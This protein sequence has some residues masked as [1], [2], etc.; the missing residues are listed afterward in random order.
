MVV[1]EAKEISRARV[2]R[3]EVYIKLS[4]K[5]NGR[6]LTK[7]KTS[8][9]KDTLNPY[10]NEAFTFSVTAEQAKIV[11]LVVT[12]AEHDPLGRSR[13]I[14]RVEL[15]TKGGV[16]ETAHW[17][18]ALTNQRHAIAQWHTLHD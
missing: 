9:K 12:L 3:A 10:F 17:S 7:K 2:Q 8:A 15:G 13:P 4:L 16:T 11:T 1:I 14:G 6:R 18:N 5:L